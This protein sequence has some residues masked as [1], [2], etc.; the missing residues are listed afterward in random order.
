V[1]APG[2][3]PT[4][5]PGRWARVVRTRGPAWKLVKATIGG[6]VRYRVPGLAAEAAYFT[7]LS[8]PPLIFGLVGTIGFVAGRFSTHT[9]TR[10]REQT[11]SVAS[12]VLTQDAVTTVIS[13]TLD[14]VLSGGR[15]EIISIGFLLALWSGSRALNV[16]VDTITIL[17]GMADKRGIVRTRSAS[18]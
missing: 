12:R 14:D 15:F 4:K 18:Q 13:P 2:T 3:P 11:L 16:F 8:L 9:I 7:I 17:Y 5:T 1:S 6:C 10:L